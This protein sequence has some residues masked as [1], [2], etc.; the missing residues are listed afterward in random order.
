MHPSDDAGPAV[1]MPRYQSHKKVWALQIKSVIGGGPSDYHAKLTF[2]EQGYAPITVDSKMFA[3]YTP[4]EGD[5][6]VI[7]DDGYKSFSPKKAFE[8]GYRLLPH[9]RRPTVEELEAI[10][11][12]EDDTPVTINPD[13]SITAA[14][15]GIVGGKIVGDPSTIKP[16]NR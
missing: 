13:G 8:E 12:S 5:Y 10:L 6:Y 4:V 11:N 9:G 15:G 16:G 1:E 14:S 3:R 2:S 7:Y